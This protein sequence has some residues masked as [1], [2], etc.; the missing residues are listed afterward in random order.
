M[1]ATLLWDGTQ[2][3]IARSAQPYLVTLKG[4]GFTPLMASFYILVVRGRSF[5]HRVVD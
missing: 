3:D 5:G 1:I 2:G 4:T